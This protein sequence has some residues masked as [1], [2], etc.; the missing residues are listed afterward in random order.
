MV[1]LHVPTGKLDKVAL[2]QIFHQS[3]KKRRGDHIKWFVITHNCAG[4]IFKIY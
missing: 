2:T 3:V 1:S 4:A